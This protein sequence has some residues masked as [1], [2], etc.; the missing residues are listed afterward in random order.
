MKKP[1][2]PS[3]YPLT[4]PKSMEELIT[5]QLDEMRFFAFHGL[6]REER[7]T[8]NEFAVTLSLAFRPGGGTVTAIPDTVDYGQVF[9]V[10]KAAM[11]HPRDLLETLAMEITEELHQRFP[12]IRQAEIRISKLHPPI[13]GFQGNV[14]VTYRKIFD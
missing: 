2:I 12:F 13:P 7:K 3:L 1:A 9:Q 11:Q 4:T 6:H 10:V 5:V 14:A 8:G